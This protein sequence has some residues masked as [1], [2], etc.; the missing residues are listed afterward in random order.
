MLGILGTAVLAGCSSPLQQTPIKNKTVRDFVATELFYIAHRGSGDNWTE[1]TMTAY[2]NAVK[3]GAQAI[4]VSVHRT[5]DDVFVCHHDANLKR[6]TGIDLDIAQATAL[7]LEGISNDAREWLGP[8]SGLEPIPTLQEVL[9]EMPQECFL[10]IED[11][12]GAHAEELL[13]VLD[14]VP[15]GRDRIV[16]KQNSTAAG[17]EL[18]SARGY[19]T[20]G[21]FAPDTVMRIAELA[22]RFDLLGIHDSATESV[23]LELTNIGKPIICW[24]IHTRWQRD[25]FLSWGVRGMMCSNYPYVT[26]FPARG[27]NLQDSF[28][29]GLR[30]IGDLPD[31]ISWAAQPLIIADQEALRISGE[32]KSSYT[33]GS[34]SPGKIVF[35]ELCFS[36]RWPQLVAKNHIAGVSFAVPTDAPYRAFEDS[37]ER[38]MHIQIETRGEISVW[39]ATE[40]GPQRLGRSAIPQGV[41]GEWADLTLRSWKSELQVSVDGWQM[42]PVEVQENPLHGYVSLLCLVPQGQPVDFRHVAL[43]A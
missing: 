38:G 7:E 25:H 43:T 18:A 35:S 5:S 42:D 16:W 15:Q 22:G 1:H 39:L 14:M 32:K 3:A 6:L 13:S 29:T 37:Q 34:I 20:W 12:T 10:F 9:D 26:G 8:H 31:A 41:P 27:E 30:G 17:Y 28:G 33:L 11:K 24:E 19:L 21:Y 36:V 2:R 40:T 23:L 4:E